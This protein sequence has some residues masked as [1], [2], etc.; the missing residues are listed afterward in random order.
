M[1]NQVLEQTNQ[2]LL[3]DIVVRQNALFSALFQM[4]VAR[5]DLRSRALSD[6][7]AMAYGEFYCAVQLLD[8]H[9]LRK[10][11]ITL[12]Q[13]EEF[14]KAKAQLVAVRIEVLALAE[15]VDES[16]VE[17][18]SPDPEPAPSIPE[19]LN[20]AKDGSMSM[21]DE[22]LYSQVAEFCKGESLKDDELEFLQD[23]R[24]RVDTEMTR[25]V[26]QLNTPSTTVSEVDRSV[27]AVYT[28]LFRSRFISRGAERR[29][30]QVGE[31]LGRQT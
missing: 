29:D 18:P 5:A 6:P 23:F 14:D 4:D 11:G 21:G 27:F 8:S 17:K 3:G 16:K 24:E 19:W 15:G 31:K 20:S 13:S 2:S 1:H 12:A 7:D 26:K 28:T 22:D 10:V 9:E 25:I 30:F